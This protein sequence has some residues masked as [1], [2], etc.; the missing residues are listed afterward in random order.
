L[1]KHWPI[2]SSGRCINGVMYYSAIFSV[3]TGTEHR[4]VRCDIRSEKVDSIKLPETHTYFV[5]DMI[6]YEGRFAIVKTTD[7]PS[8]DL[9]IL[10]DGNI[11]EWTHKRF[12]LP[13][14][15]M[16]PM[17]KKTLCFRGVTNAGELIFAPWRFSESFSI[18]CF[19]PKGN[20]IRQ[21]LFE[22]IVGDDIRRRCGFDKERFY[23][24]NVWPNHI[25]SIVSF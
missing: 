7:F 13:P 9:W 5:S 24:L 17:Q 22:G 25:E 18:L 23:N 19:H 6:P 14:F 12:V 15:K 11:F 10:K 3:G 4:I 16:D 2:L 8:I 21:V 20:S 1:P